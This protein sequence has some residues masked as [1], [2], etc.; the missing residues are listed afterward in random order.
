MN[1]SN[2]LS[3]LQ[4]G[5]DLH[6]SVMSAPIG[7]CVLNAD[8]LVA[9]IV[10]DKF[11]EVAGKPREAI[12]GKNYWEPF[13]EA[14]AYYETA[15]QQVADTGVAF[16]AQE[17]ELMLIRQGKEE[18]IFV[19]FVYSPLLDASGKTSK[20][21]V[22]VLEN[23]QQVLA[24][25]RIAE[26]EEKARIAI[27][28]ANLGLYE[29][30]FHNDSMTTDKRFDEI[31]G[32][33]G[34]FK[35]RSEYAAYFHPDDLQH[36]ALA[37]EQSMITSQVDYQARIIWPDQS[38][39]WVRVTGNVVREN[40]EPYKLVGVVQD[41]T[42]IVIA[43]RKLEATEASLRQA[44][45]LAN[46]GTWHVNVDTNFTSMSP[47]LMSWFGIEGEGAD[48]ETLIGCIRED[49]REMVG[50]A[51]FSTLQP[52][53]DGIYN[54]EYTV[55]N[56]RTGQHRILH[57]LGQSFFDKDGKALRISGIARD[58]TI[59]RQLQLALEHE[60]QE[61]TEELESS[62]ARLRL[63]NEELAQ[64]A[65]IASHD[66]QEPLRKIMTFSEMLGKSLGDNISDKTK[67]YLQKINGS[68]LR[69]HTLIKDVLAYSQL[70]KE[71]E[72]FT[73]VDLNQVIE[74]VKDDFDLFIEQT[75][76]AIESDPLPVIEAIPAQMVQ[77]F[78]NLLGNSMK[79]SKQGIQPVIRI[80]IG[81]QQ[82]PNC[83][84]LALTPKATIP[85]SCF[86]ITAS[87]ST[88]TMLNRSSRSFK[89]CTG[90]RNTREQALGLP[91]AEKLPS[92]TMVRYMLWRATMRVP[93]LQSFFR[94]RMPINKYSAI[95]GGKK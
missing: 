70:V 17:V 68:S 71:T 43:Q 69:M 76:M 60:V 28:S 62:N 88:P 83:S 24:R 12:L 87:V 53:S 35:F 61:R 9:E 92:I 91:C 79:F 8:G 80:R 44:V 47:L 59:E 7:I 37:H 81:Q 72:V 73:A 50:N 49:Q 15:L 74:E 40:G 66:L 55:I 45:D 46:L 65:Y 42:D 56:C 16:H 20:I 4:L 94:W 63:S 6:Q 52:G 33:P 78:G 67:N 23:T 1:T 21:V 29:T 5:K 13:A 75:G 22:W 30:T 58:V 90:S 31:W 95:T 39:R 86:R 32:T 89:D 41:V 51:L 77:L 36:R 19:T 27:R 3:F 54:V 64:F 2:D 10:N 93:H 85:R 82:K 26:A 14:R 18:N 34:P 84:A 11:L 57:V 48:A 25:K 38:I